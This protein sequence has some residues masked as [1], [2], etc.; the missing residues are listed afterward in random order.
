MIDHQCKMGFVSVLKDGDL[1]EDIGSEI[2]SLL[3]IY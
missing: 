2:L 1:N 3:E